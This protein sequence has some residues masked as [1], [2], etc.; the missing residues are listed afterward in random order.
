MSSTQLDTT[1]VHV[2][3]PA[4][5]G[6]PG[7]TRS[8]GQS[9]ANLVFDPSIVEKRSVHTLVFRSLKRTHELFLSD[10]GAL[11]HEDDTAQKVLM[12]VKARDQY[13]PVM[14]L[15]PDD[16]A[17]GKADKSRSQ[18]H[19]E[20]P[21]GAA[22]D[23]MA[24]VAVPK[25][26][27]EY[28]SIPPATSS[29]LAIRNPDSTASAIVPRKGNAMPK[30]VWHAPWKL[31]RVVSGH[32]GWVHSLAVEPGNEWFASGSKD[33]M[34]KIWD[35]A[36]GKLKLSLTG[37]ISGVRG[38]AVSAR[39]PY[40]FSCGEDKT[41]KCWDLEYNKVIRHYHG[42]LSAV[43]CM[44]LHPTID[45]LITGGRD[46][47]GRVWDMR[48]KAQIHALNGHTGTI[49]TI[50]AQATEPQII[51]GSHD[52]TIRLWDLVAGKTRVALTHHKKSV[53]STALHPKLNMFVSGAP[54][55]L[56]QWLCP[57][58][59][60]VQNMEGHSAIVNSVSVNSDGVLVSAADNGTMFMWDWRTGYNF[61]RMQSC[62]QPGS[63][64]SEAGIFATTFDQSGCRLITA[65]ADKTI[66]FY[67]EDEDADE[68]SHPIN[69]KPDII[70]RKR[71]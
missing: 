65:E 46:A 61:Q 23:G 36:S 18:L 53:R 64:E 57:D 40:L 35:L 5:P 55:N 28:K 14:H 37:H 6:R 39:Q 52:T 38:L 15:V 25:E 45:I 30:P 20:S 62:A 66:K 31:M 70:K 47:C 2:R 68:E 16:A 34:I 1:P 21:A 71:Y 19:Q 3:L 59:K 56:K 29:A 10:D 24:L 49:A 12:S 58:G 67:K 48:T 27:T 13:G 9:P 11:P 32:T 69:W 63:I 42:H 7:I 54:D 50:N 33:R 60:F 4:T 26:A 22:G 17:S 44:A 41:V 43:Y 8:S 51:T